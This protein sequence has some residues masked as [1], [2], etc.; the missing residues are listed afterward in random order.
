MYELQR[1]ATP[2]AAVIV[3]A[4]AAVIVDAGVGVVD[5]ANRVACTLKI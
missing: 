5:V 3:D 2:A 1:V 4:A